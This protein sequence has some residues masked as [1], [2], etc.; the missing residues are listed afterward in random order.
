MG[1]WYRHK[2]RETYWIKYKSGGVWQYESTH[3]TLER[4]AKRLLQLR[5]GDTAKGISVTSQV[6]RLKFDDARDDLINYHKANSRDTTKLEARIRKH[7]TPYFGGKKMADISTAT[8]NAYVAKRK[9]DVVVLPARTLKRERRDE[10]RK[11]VANATINRELAWLKHMFSLACDAGKLMAKP[12][13]RLLTEDNARQ[14]FFEPEH[15]R[16]VLPVLPEDLRPVVMFAYITGWRVKSEVLPLEWRQVDLKAGEVRLE[17]GTTK[18]KEGRTFPF[19]RELRVLLEAQ[20]AEHERLKKRGHV[21][22]WVFFRMVANGRGGPLRPKP[23][24]SMSKAFQAACRRVGLGHRILHDCR[25]SAVRNLERAGVPRSVAM[26]L[27]GHK[28]ESVYRRYAIAHA[29]DLRV[30]VQRLDALAM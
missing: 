2:G 14:G 15:L 12:K 26:K 23:I 10:V 24:T 6:G 17:P 4:D 19:T 13:I 3:S 9:A 30:A 8:V 25:R 21:V 29:D 16:S 5:E 18:N 22:P 7:L 1:C 28:T 20:Y 11:P 27:T